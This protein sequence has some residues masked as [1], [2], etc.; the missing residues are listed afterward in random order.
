MLSNTLFME[1]GDFE[2][3]SIWF[4]SFSCSSNLSS[5]RRQLLS[6]YKC[7]RN[8]MAFPLGGHVVP[9][10]QNA[11]INSVMGLTVFMT[12]VLVIPIISSLSEYFSFPFFSIL[13]QSL[14]HLLTRTASFFTFHR[15][16]LDVKHLQF[17]NSVDAVHFDYGNRKCIKRDNLN[18]QNLINASK[19]LIHFLAL[20]S[21]HFSYKMF[22]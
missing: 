5:W 11:D 8:V 9:Y 4:S 6:G 21:L 3:C 22:S 7:F 2:G 1:Y 10:H 16:W 19:L 13:I 18:Q 20:I 14:G 12:Q 17:L 15:A